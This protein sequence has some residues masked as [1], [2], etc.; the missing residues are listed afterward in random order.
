MHDGDKLPRRKDFEPK[1][2]RPWI[3]NL[4][5]VEVS[6]DGELLFRLVGTNLHG[7]F[8]GE[9]TGLSAGSLPPDIGRAFRQEILKACRSRTPIDATQ[10]CVV[11]GEEKTFNDIY[12]PLSDDNERIDT[13]L[14][15][16]FQ[17]QGK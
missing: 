2:L 11:D 13:I 3:G 15:A 1:S 12:L 14:F 6:S 10:V 7:R 8:G 16:S 17:V 5:F 4:A 9:Y